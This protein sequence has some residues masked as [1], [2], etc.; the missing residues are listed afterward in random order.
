[1]SVTEKVLAEIGKLQ[2]EVGDRLPSERNLAERCEISRS[3]VRSAL[4]ELQSQRVLDVKQGSGY[5]LASDFALK[6][7]LGG[8]DVGWSL[9]KV[10]QV[11][12]ARTLVAVHAMG[13][14][15]QAMTESAMQELEGCLID[16]GK[17]VINVDVQTMDILHNRFINIV[18]ECCSNIEYIRMLNE[19]KVPS[20]FTVS[21][22]RMAEGDERNAYFSEH[23]NLFQAIKNRDHEMA[24]DVCARIYNKLSVLFEKYAYTVFS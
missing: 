6:Q 21:I 24:R 4:K 18:H 16:L 7:A 5:F 2:L 14:G 19:V 23:V 15:S 20:H 22:L 9:Q 12:E 3:S 8:Q 17:A 13:L 11:F 1:M 10:Q